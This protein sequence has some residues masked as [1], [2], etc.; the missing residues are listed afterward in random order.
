V[1]EERTHP[2][3]PPVPGGL[4]KIAVVDD[5]AAVCKALERILRSY[6]YRVTTFAS[7]EAFLA[8]GLHVPPAC[9]VLDIHL[10][11]MNGLELNADLAAQ[12]FHIPTIFI[13]AHDDLRT[14]ARIKKTDAVAYLTKPFDD[15]ALIE[16]IHQAVGGTQP[17]TSGAVAPG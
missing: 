13:T 3:A 2:I 14:R 6:G 1:S 17:G 11:G 16:A 12:G 7:A 9:L 4:S 15:L 10:G 8:H 5:E